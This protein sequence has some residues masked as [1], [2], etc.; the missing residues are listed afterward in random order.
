[1]TLL[2]NLVA[3]EPNSGGVNPDFNCD[4]SVDQDDVAS[5]IITVAGGPCP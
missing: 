1:M 2:I 3:G 5:L 4:G